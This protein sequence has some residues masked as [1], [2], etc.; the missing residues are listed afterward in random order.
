MGVQSTLEYRTLVVLQGLSWS[1]S[2]NFEIERNCV[3]GLALAEQ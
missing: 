1:E 3:K 2:F